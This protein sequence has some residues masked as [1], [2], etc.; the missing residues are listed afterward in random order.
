MRLYSLIY[1]KAETCQDTEMY[2]RLTTKVQVNCVSNEI[3]FEKGGL[4]FFDT[5][6]NS[7]SI[8]KWTKYT[9]LNNLFIRLQFTGKFCVTLYRYNYYY[10]EII[11]EGL[12]SQIIETAK[13]EIATADIPVPMME[14]GGIIGFSMEAFQD[15]SVFYQGE[16]FTNVSSD[17]LSEVNIAITMCTYHREV[18]IY[19][20][21]SLLNDHIFSDPESPLYGHLRLYIADNG[22]SLEKDQL[23]NNFVNIFPQQSY[24]GSGGFVRGIIEI[25]KSRQEKGHTH[26]LIMDDDV[27]IEPEGLVRNYTFLC[28]L[29]PEYRDRQIGGAMLRTDHRW[30]QYETCGRFMGLG[31]QSVKGTRDLRNLACVID[32]EKEETHDYQAW[33][34]TCIPIELYQKLGFSL[35]F[36]MKGDDVE[37]GLRI[38]T[39][40]ITLNGISVWHE[41]FES[42]DNYVGKYFCVR[43]EMIMSCMHHLLTKKRVL[44]ELR[45]AFL[46]H[47]L[48]YQYVAL[49]MHYKALED[50]CRGL[51]WLLG[52]DGR[53]L[54][55]E[56]QQ[57]DYNRVPVEQLSINFDFD[58]MYR[59]CEQTES[60]KRRWFRR[61][62]FNGFFF[63]ANH[64]TIVSMTRCRIINFYRAKN[65]LF[66]NDF[67]GKAFQSQKNYSELFRLTKR[68]LRTRRLIKKNFDRVA[69][70]YCDRQNETRTLAFWKRYLNL[71]DDPS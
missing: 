30:L 16:Y 70:E 38:G 20:N 67:T 60:K 52:L 1:P 36:F 42:K 49:D 14:K 44:Q 9:W 17:K 25:F 43:N 71:D 41:A 59:N 15:D 21:L 4:V 61:L 40:S 46:W 48:C 33:F 22:E 58:T 19:R 65:V 63:P 31:V 55:S 51:D 35:P 8:G 39:Q 66:Y 26:I 5:Y 57:K 45:R 10:R 50:F 28:L 62:T 68:Y 7:F 2:F 32:N 54:Y 13:G 11:K 56:L 34:Y 37:Y 47:T 6:Y 69:K 53:A 27:I 24:G 29:K 23:E 12:S 3:I 64:D 18:Y